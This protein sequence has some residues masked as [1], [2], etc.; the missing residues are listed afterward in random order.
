MASAFL[1]SA[2]WLASNHAEPTTHAKPLDTVAST[3]MAKKPACNNTTHMTD[4]QPTIAELQALLPQTPIDDPTLQSLMEQVV[5]RPAA[6]LVPL[7]WQDNQW[8]VLLTQRSQHVPHHKGQIAFPGGKWEPNDPSLQHT[9][10]RET[11]EEIGLPPSSIQLIGTLPAVLSSS[12]FRM[13]P[14]VGIIP[15]S[16]ICNPDPGEI[17]QVLSIPLYALLSQPLHIKF[18]RGQGSF[19]YP[20]FSFPPP[21]SSVSNDIWGATARILR[22]LLLLIAPNHPSLQP[23]TDDIGVREHL[24]L[25]WLSDN[26]APT[27]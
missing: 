11:H 2:A 26:H 13:E 25:K 27:K 22:S 12:G 21:D 16:P 6:V 18:W 19:W 9:A 4:T 3:S 1:S 23:P 5:L 17:A 10:L 15:P 8:H 14:H 20:V 24:S 7:F